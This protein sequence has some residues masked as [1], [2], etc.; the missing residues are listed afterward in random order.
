MVESLKKNDISAGYEILSNAHALNKINKNNI[1]KTVYDTVSVVMTFYNA[2]KFIKQAVQSVLSQA[3]S[4]EGLEQIMIDFVIVDDCSQDGSAKIVKDAIKEYKE[5]VARAS[6]PCMNINYITAEKN[7]GCGGARKLG[8]ENATGDYIMFLDADDYYI[9][10]NFVCRAHS[11]IKREK[12]DI[13]EFGV[14]MNNEGQQPI[15]A[16]VQQPLRLKNTDD[17]AEIAMFNDNIIKFNVWSKI[18]KKSIVDSYPYSTART[19][20]DVRTVPYWLKAAKDILVMNTIEVNYRA[21]SGSIIRD[22]IIDTRVG[23]ITAIAGL[24][25]DFK[26][27]INVLKAMY[28]RAMVDITALC[29]GHSEENE[30]FSAMSKL[31]TEMLKYIYPTDWMKLTFNPDV[32]EF[33][34]EQKKYQNL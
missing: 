22:N 27:N 19:F 8:I 20:E 16:V 15:N 34:V 6:L 7:L 30:G 18:Y 21:S 29:D 13:V 11:M 12:V 2:E 4:G 1:P 31:N 10:N 3:M 24:F 9:N 28:N 33:Y 26:N 5:Q 32:P 14:R 25:P 23:T 17:I